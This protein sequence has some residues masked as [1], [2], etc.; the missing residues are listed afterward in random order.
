MAV[1][2]TDACMQQLI[3]MFGD[4]IKAEKVWENASPNSSFAAQTITFDTTQ[5]DSFVVK[6]RGAVAGSVNT[7]YKTSYFYWL[8]KTATRLTGFPIN[9]IDASVMAI[10]MRGVSITTAGMAFGDGAYKL[11]TATTSKENNIYATPEAIY[12]LKGVK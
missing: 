12:G 10:P 2:R 5:Y 11:C 1:N 8:P 3:N 4:C 9:Q 7:D 6:M